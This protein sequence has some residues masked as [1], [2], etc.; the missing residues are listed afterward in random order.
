MSR[1]FPFA[2]VALS[3]AVV[4]AVLSPSRL[5][6][7]VQTPDPAVLMAQAK[8]FFEALDYE[9]AVSALDQAIVVLE[10]RPPQDPARRSLPVA[11][12]MRGRSQFGL[13]KETEARADFVALLK[14]DPVYTLTGQVSP[15]VVALFDEVMK[16]TVTTMRLAVTP[17]TAE[18]RVDGVIVPATTSMPIAIGDHVITARQIGYRPV[19]QP[20]AIVSGQPAEVNITLERVSS[21]LAVVTSPP[22]VQVIIDGV[23]HGKTETGPPPPDYAERAAR[24]GVPASELSQV[25][26]VAEMQPGAHVV[27]FKADCHVGTQRR[28]TVDKPDD[29]TLD[30][31]KL[32]RAIAS[33]SIKTSQP[34]A[35]VYVDGQ[36]R[37][38]APMTMSDVCEGEHL[39]EVRSG[40]GRFFRRMTARTGDKVEMD[41]ALKP[42]FALV[43][44][45]GQATGLNTDLRMTIERALE[46]LQSVTL[47]APPADQLEQ[48]L[49][50]QQLT[51]AW[52]AFDA[53]KR[54][55]AQAA[56]LGAATRRDL[57]ARIAKTFDAQGVAS[58]T[59]PSP[60]DRSRLV[61]SLLAAGSGDPD[62]V[63]VTIDRPETFAAA[64]AQV[65]RAPSFFRPSLGLTAIDVRDVAGAVV[66]GVDASGPA[67]KAGIAAGD[68]IVK[69]NAQPIA[70]A[71]ALNA[72][73]AARKADESLT[74]ELKDKT[75]APKRADVAVAMAPRLVG[76]YD[77]TLLV[78]R[79][80]LDLRNRLQKP[81]NPI[82]DSVLRLN[83]AAALA[84]IENW[85]DARIELQR[86]KLPD[87]P[88]V[89]NGTV[90]Y[91][92][93]L[94]AD[95]L[96]SRADADAAFNAAAATDALI[97]EDG[98]S[99]KD[100]VEAR[101]AGRP[102]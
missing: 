27:E 81:G 20:A 22:G 91:L 34:G 67:A 98:P 87:G 23:S 16:A 58:V 51:P 85:S 40:S 96:G 102:R 80:L 18:V 54:P 71:V 88:G 43:S 26:L 28:L 2:S 49:K 78:N 60:L 15:K 10:G 65:D 75:G 17:P 77:Q 19:T 33:V 99:V 24:A 64:I 62:V 101:R 14:A 21:V 38:M 44:A 9:H 39:V 13:S 45:S 55:L 30:P 37:G 74:L 66:I 84:R 25:M 5:V 83:L 94:C 7:Q 68:V 29:Y 70:D 79:M 61:V 42:A 90:Q 31:V 56:D 1:R 50:A 97:S 53:S 47:F 4:S 100:L 41:A 93:G 52:L 89:S 48:V 92:L 32:E 8:Q 59:V 46:G 76:L 82:E 36:Q 72:L 11:Y 95:K 57:T 86:V 69:A 6:A 73:L 3:L 12:E 35:T 63:E